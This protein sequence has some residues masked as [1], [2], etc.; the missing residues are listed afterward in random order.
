M[1][2]EIIREVNYPFGDTDEEQ[3]GEPVEFKNINEAVNHLK[4][5]KGKGLFSGINSY[6][7]S[8]IDKENQCA[9]FTITNRGR[10]S[11]DDFTIRP[12]N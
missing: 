3:W 9:Y 1:K 4:N 10:Y 6:E 8:E 11:G 2:F 5:D 12:F 7:F